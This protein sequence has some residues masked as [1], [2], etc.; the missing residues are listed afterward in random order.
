MAD[1]M[2]LVEG[3]VAWRLTA[4]VA[5]GLL[6]GIERE[7]QKRPKKDRDAGLRTF[8]L[9]SLMGGLAAQTGIPLVSAAAVLFAVAIALMTRVRPGFEP[10][11]MTTEVA[12]VIASILGILA[13]TRPGDAIAAAVVVVVVISS[14]VPLHRFARDWLTERELRDGLLFATAALVILPLLPNHAIDPL[15]LV[16][17]FALW[18]LAV[19]LM[20]VSSFSHFATRILGPKY[21]LFISGFAGGFVSS[22]ATIADLGRRAK[23]DSRLI[24]SCAAGSMAS[25]LGSLVYLAILVGAADPDILRPLMIPFAVASALT[26]GYSAF[27]A[28]RGNRADFTSKALFE[29]F[30][31]RTALIFIAL[32]FAF[33]LLSWALIAWFGSALVYVSVI[34]TALVDAHAAAVSVATLVAAGKLGAEAGSFAILVGF[35]SNMLAKTPTSFAFGGTAFGVR[36]T[37]G[38]GLLVSGLWCG[39]LWHATI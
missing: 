10:R 17:P 25:I 27:L 31:F 23:G 37:I 32:V 5:I 14:R 35:S 22:T 8:V 11:G 3:S 30:D 1:L 15:G 18:R 33:S 16:N 12:L 36:L 13:Q 6:I 2:H 20:G 4:A 28:W 9:V 7:R 19:V 29:T 21:G 24:E 38:L 26:L 39:A 34:G